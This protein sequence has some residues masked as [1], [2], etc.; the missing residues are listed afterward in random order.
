M[1]YVAVAANQEQSN[2][3]ILRADSGGATRIVAG[4]SSMAYLRQRSRS[5]GR[6]AHLAL[7]LKKPSQIS[8]DVF[9][10]LDDGFLVTDDFRL[11]LE[12]LREL[13]LILQYSLLVADDL[14]LIFQQLL[15]IPEGGL[16]HSG[17][18]F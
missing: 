11:I 4:I 5:P 12:Q 10:I 18:L 13:I 6:R 8:Q 15:L 1:G 7:F 3:E 9:L 2:R 16:C 17:F 14:P